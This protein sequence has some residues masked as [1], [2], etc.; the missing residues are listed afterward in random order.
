[1]TFSSGCAFLPADHA[2]GSQKALLHLGD[3]H[4]LPEE[5]IEHRQDCY[6]VTSEMR[7]AHQRLWLREDL[8]ERLCGIVTETA[9]VPISGQ[10][11][12]IGRERR[13]GPTGPPEEPA[14]L[15][16]GALGCRER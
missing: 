10:P 2:A 16:A 14:D 11:P 8:D 6:R 13:G 5:V 9:G 3:Q 1:M 7:A 15:Q 4:V 12:H